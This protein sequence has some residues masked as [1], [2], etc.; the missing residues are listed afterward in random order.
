M[1]AMRDLEQEKLRSLHNKSLERVSIS[2]R[3]FLRKATFKLKHTRS[4][5]ILSLCLKPEVFI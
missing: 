2:C 5:K 1:D 3:I 4:Q